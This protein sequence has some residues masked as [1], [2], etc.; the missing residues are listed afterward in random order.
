MSA[1]KTATADDSAAEWIKILYASQY[2]IYC[3]LLM[4]QP[5]SHAHTLF[6]DNENDDD[7][8]FTMWKENGKQVKM[9]VLSIE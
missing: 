3:L 1:T 6:I 4:L 9:K 7:V 2:K 5:H 8:E